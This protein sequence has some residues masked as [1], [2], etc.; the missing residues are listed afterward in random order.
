[1][2]LSILSFLTIVSI[3]PISFVARNLQWK[4][5]LL[6]ARQLLYHGVGRHIDTSY[7]TTE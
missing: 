7:K 1:M 6:L 3:L 5:G 4:S 2:S